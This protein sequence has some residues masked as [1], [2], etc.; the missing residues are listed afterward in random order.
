[1]VDVTVIGGIVSGLNGTLNLAKAF[2]D[3]RDLTQVQQKTIELQRS[4]LDVQ[5]AAMSAQQSQNEL[6]EE[7]KN[8]KEQIKA[9]DDWNA[10]ASRYELKDY[11]DQTFAFE[12]RVDQ[13]QGQPIHKLCPKCFNLNKKSILQ[14]SHTASTSQQSYQ[15]NECQNNYLL[16]RRVARSSVA[17]RSSDWLG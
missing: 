14:F 5:Q 4:I 11:G 17:H 15:C 12:L 16:G 8:L 6:L 1:M 10:E 9:S 13:A 3:L 7:I 2:S